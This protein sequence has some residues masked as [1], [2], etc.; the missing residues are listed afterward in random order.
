MFEIRIGLLQQEKSCFI[1]P[2]GYIAVQQVRNQ[3]IP[4]IDRQ[5]ADNQIL[6]SII[7]RHNV[8]LRVQR[9]PACP[10]HQFFAFQQLVRL[11]FRF[12]MHT[13]GAKNDETDPLQQC[14]FFSSQLNVR[15]TV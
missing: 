7:D 15:I 11:F 3:N 6:V 12:G 5:F 1:F 2:I 14:T 10:H 13:P 8:Q 9:L 4:K